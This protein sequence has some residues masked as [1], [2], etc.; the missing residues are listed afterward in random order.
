MTE[1]TE[2]AP[3]G[4]ADVVDALAVKL[5]A[6]GLEPVPADQAPP[7]ERAEGPLEV[8]ARRAVRLKHYAERWG[9]RL[10]AMYEDASLDKLAIM[11]DD[12]ESAR[13][14]T[15][16]LAA[17]SSRT[18]VL[19]G[20]VGTGKTHAAYAIGNAAVARGIWTEGWTVTDLLEAMRPNGDAA[21][22]RDVARCPLLILDDL[23]AGKAT[24]WAV[25][26][27]TSLVD[28]RLRENRRQIVTTNL[29]YPA[30]VEAWGARLMDRLAYRWTTVTLT[31]PSRRKGW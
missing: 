6:R 20:D 11:T 30:L 19:A 16:W 3:V 21:G 26:A 23:G 31:G 12:P 2:P 28:A 7:A 14:V 29:P 25:D 27:L 13:K 5:R 8:E 18:L 15:T 10:P 22:A 1:H 24:D 9:K 17:E 4:T